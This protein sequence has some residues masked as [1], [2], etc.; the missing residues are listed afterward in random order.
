MVCNQYSMSMF[1]CVGVEGHHGVT[2]IDSLLG[3]FND[4]A[5][6]G[7]EVETQS[8][9]LLDEGAL[10][11]VV[12]S[13]QR[14]G[15]QLDLSHRA[16]RGEHQRLLFLQFGLYLGQH[17]TVHG[18]GFQLGLQPGI[19]LTVA[20]LDHLLNLQLVLVCCLLACHSGEGYLWNMICSCCCPS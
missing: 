20:G 5:G 19:E 18:G 2:L 12:V 11:L 8:F 9:V 17:D 16:R 7:P 13:Q 15:V 6:R 3:G 1:G 14:M 10:Q 4:L